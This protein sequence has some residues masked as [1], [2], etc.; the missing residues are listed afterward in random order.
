[1]SKQKEHTC[2]L[3]TSMRERLTNVENNLENFLRY[4]QDFRIVTRAADD[5]DTVIRDLEILIRRG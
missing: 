1:M 2:N 4:R 5:I 3:L